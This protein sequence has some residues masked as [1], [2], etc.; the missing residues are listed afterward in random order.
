MTRGL[1]A[2]GYQQHL[3]IPHA[4]DLT[5]QHSE[6]RRVT[7]VVRRVDREQRGPNA[8]QPCRR[9][10]VARRVPLIEDIVGVSAETAAE[11]L[12]EELVGLL[13][14]RCRLIERQI[15]AVRSNA[16]EY[17]GELR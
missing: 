3:A 10:V 9:V 2:G 14:R 5:V 12:V 13:P 7:L 4:L 11:T 16:E 15:A 1:V 6:F 8:F 17:R